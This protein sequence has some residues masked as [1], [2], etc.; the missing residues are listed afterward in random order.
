MIQKSKTDPSS[1][2]R[3]CLLSLQLFVLVVGQLPEQAAGLD[4]LG[5]RMD[6]SSMH[7]TF[8][9]F[10]SR[11][12]RVE[13]WLYDQPF[14]ADEKAHFALVVDP[15]TKFWAV[16]LPVSSLHAAG[17]GSTIYYGYRMWGPNWTFASS[18]NKG[19][20]AG[21]AADVDAQGNRFNPNK[22]LLDPYV[23]EVSHD[24]RSAQQSSDAV[25]LSGTNRDLDTGRV[26][27]KGIVLHSL[28]RLVRRCFRSASSKFKWKTLV[29]SR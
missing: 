18:W 4:A 13:A 25:F 12:T 5:A 2:I 28:Q 22:L 8:R 1:R 20:H 26:A 6:D 15:T 24:A 21:F 17:I 11:A 3:H 16:T 9:V 19:S 27:P 23:L 29:S 7:L 10:S 14:G